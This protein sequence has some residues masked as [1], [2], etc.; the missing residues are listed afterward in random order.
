VL[1]I[2]LVRLA[3]R[4]AGPPLQALAE[5]I[6]RL[7]RGAGQVVP[8]PVPAPAAASAPAASA[9][10]AAPAAPAPARRSAAP[11]ADD[12][13][14]P[15]PAKS[16]SFK[17]AKAAAAPAAGAATPTASAPDVLAEPEPAAA[18]SP[19]VSVD[20]D[21]VIVAWPVIIE[22]LGPATKAAMREAQP[23]SYE[24]NVLTLGIPKEHFATATGRLKGE[25]D[26]IR[27]ALRARLGI[28]PKFQPV[29]HEGFTSSG[30]R[31]GASPR[32]AAS[33]G[34]DAPI[35]EPPPDD[36]PPAAF[37][38]DDPDDDYV[39]PD[40]IIDTPVADAAVDSVGLFTKSFDATVVEEVT[41]D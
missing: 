3:R 17:A 32:A 33:S 9:A 24:N 18:A 29:A 35:G 25:A 40:E 20:I 21:D 39:A 28:S 22:G 27:E 1:E 12:A 7:E 19:A 6:E 31:G 15:P 5:R 34:D 8:A 16:K 23:M 2:A 4:D 38:A 11:A 26:N 37:L 36:E 10:P 41:R 30:P 14:A 13:A